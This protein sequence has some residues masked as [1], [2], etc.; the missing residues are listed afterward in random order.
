MK[1]LN[2][3]ML[4]LPLILGY[5]LL[6][7]SSSFYGVNY[8]LKPSQNNIQ[9]KGSIQ[10]GVIAGTVVNLEG[11]PVAKAEVIA[12]PARG[13]RGIHPHAFTDAKGNYRIAELEPDTYYVA[14]HKESEV[15]ADT[16]ATFY[17]AGFTESP[18]VTLLDSQVVDGVI[19]R[20]G[21]KSARLK[22]RIIDAITKKP[23]QNAGVTLRRADN[24]SSLYGFS[25]ESK[26]SVLVPPIPFTIEVEADGYEDW[27]YSN[28]GS[29][30]HADALLLASGATKDLTI[31]LHPAK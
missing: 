18:S 14:A 4:T 7:G 6:V 11:Q 5:H 24:A 27:K 13:Y 28:D 1:K 29:A 16:I 3:I 20:F 22:G 19:I 21:P 8:A 26:F 23:I 17:S 10:G 30:K 12:R 25:S 9:D 2:L 15:N 31:A